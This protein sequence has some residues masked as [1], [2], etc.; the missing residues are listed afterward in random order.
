M[1][2]KPYLPVHSSLWNPLP[3]NMLNTALLSQE[4]LYLAQ[5]APQPSRLN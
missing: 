2:S 1:L 5:P 3:S 4:P